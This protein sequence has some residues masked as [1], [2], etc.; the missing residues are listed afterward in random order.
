M[1]ACVWK[2]AFSTALCMTSATKRYQLENVWVFSFVT[3]IIYYYKGSF[4]AFS[5]KIQSTGWGQINGTPI[6]SK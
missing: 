4:I 1:G 5:T 2:P 3:N 6:V